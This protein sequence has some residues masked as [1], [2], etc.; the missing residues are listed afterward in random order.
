[1][2]KVTG[3]AGMAGSSRVLTCIGLTRNIGRDMLPALTVTPPRVCGGFIM[4][5]AT[6]V[7]LLLVRPGLYTATI[8]IIAPGDT[9]LAGMYD[10]PLTTRMFCESALKICPAS[11]SANMN[12]F[13][14]SPLNRPVS[15]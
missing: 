1:M 7:V 13:T 3:P 10:A 11:S 5:G 8:E 2:V 12:L 15:S 6:T 4:S 14:V 9:V